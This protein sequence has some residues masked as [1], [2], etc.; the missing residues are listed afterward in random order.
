[1]S[2]YLPLL[3]ITCHVVKGFKKKIKPQNHEYSFSDMV[4]A[5]SEEYQII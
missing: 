3:H 1:M 2:T 5:I 4:Y